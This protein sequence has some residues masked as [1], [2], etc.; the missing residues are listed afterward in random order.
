REHPDVPRRCAGAEPEFAIVREIVSF[1]DIREPILE[2]ACD[3]P[4]S[5]KRLETGP[6]PHLAL[7]AV[8]RD[9]ALRLE[10]HFLLESFCAHPTD[11]AIVRQNRCRGRLQPDVRPG[12]R[13]F[14]GDGLVERVPLENDS[15][16]VPGVS[17][18]DCQFRAVRGEDLRA[19]DL[20]ADP[21]L[22][23]GQFR[24]LDEMPSEAFAAT[25]GRAD[26]LPLLDQEDR[27][28]TRLN[29]SHEW[30]SYAVFCLKKKRNAN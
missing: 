22:V 16:L 2:G 25:H 14:L 13:G 28:S 26:L 18:L 29:S 21:F 30:I 1:A 20:A 24:V 9:D 7:I 27:K 8:R 15:D 12:L 19:L 11:T 23:E 17:L 3:V 5:E 4:R 6:A 10:V